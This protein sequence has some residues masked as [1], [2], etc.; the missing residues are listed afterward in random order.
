MTIS[1]GAVHL[2]DLALW[3]THGGTKHASQWVDGRSAKELARAWLGSRPDH[4]P[5]DIESMLGR[6]PD[7]VRRSSG[8]P[9]P[10]GSSPSMIF[11]GEPRNTRGGCTLP[12]CG[13]RWGRGMREW[14]AGC[15]TGI[16]APH[17]CRS[18]A[19]G[20]IVSFVAAGKRKY[21]VQ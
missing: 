13:R 19:A 6:H 9:S 18:H 12:R 10:R 2:T 14:M 3:E 5:D 15:D 4:M 8:A 7:S 21:G 20:H 16:W 11:A 17:V 1:K